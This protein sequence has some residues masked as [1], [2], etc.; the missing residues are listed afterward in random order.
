MIALAATTIAGLGLLMA[1]A[2]VIISRAANAINH[3]SSLQQIGVAERELFLSLVE[4]RIAWMNDYM[5]AF[6]ER[7]NEWRL[8]VHR[9]VANEP[10]GDLPWERR[11]MSLGM[12]AGWM[13]DQQIVDDIAIIDRHQS[14]ALDD[15][16]DWIRE[17]NEKLEDHQVGP[18]SEGMSFAHDALGA[19]IGHMTRYLYVG[20]IQRQD[21]HSPLIA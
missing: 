5:E 10:V 2:G 7:Q 9:L 14:K 11:L 6:I 20:D 19:M 3:S 21:S 13:F 15:Y 1:F 17:G 4:T 16:W 12:K 18:D 8:Q